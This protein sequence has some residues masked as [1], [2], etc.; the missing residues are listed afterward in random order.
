MDIDLAYQDVLEKLKNNQRPLL[1][2]T[3]SEY[4]Y[5]ISELT[6]SINS[7]KLNDHKVEKIL[8]LLGHTRGGDLNLEGSLTSI[9]SSPK[10]NPR[11]LIFALAAAEIHLI[12]QS[13]LE[14]RRVGH[15]FIE[16]LR[17][18]LFHPHI[19]VVEWCLRTVDLLGGQAIILKKDLIKIRPGFFA[20]FNK[21]KRNIRSIIDMLLKRFSPPTT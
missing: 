15:E 7:E 18:L 8:C 1:K 4:Q 5:F 20:I 12:K 19:E 16:V 17:N 10:M 9:L 13:K 6:D 11:N 21:H 2:F 3:P 14:G